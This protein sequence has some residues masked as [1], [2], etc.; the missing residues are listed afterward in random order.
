MPALKPE[1]CDLLLLEAMETGDLDAML[2]LYEPDATFVVSSGRVVT[3]HA[4]IRQVLQGY[5]NRQGKGDGRRGSGGAERRRLG[6][7]MIVSPVRPPG[8]SV[9]GND[10]TRRLG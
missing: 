5:I 2:A 1:E 10:T 6:Q 9:E 3:G 8:R 7:W 4:A